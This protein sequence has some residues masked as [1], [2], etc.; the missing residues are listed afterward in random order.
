MENTKVKFED[1]RGRRNFSHVSQ[2]EELL[3]SQH[4]IQL[5]TALYEERG[6]ADE[7]WVTG[8]NKR[9]MLHQLLLRTHCRQ[10]SESMPLT[11]NPST[12]SKLKTAALEDFLV[13][14]D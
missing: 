8:A 5:T 13:N 1:A 2:L 6:N 4:N 9:G 10:A 11:K 7:E 12:L 3:A 14:L